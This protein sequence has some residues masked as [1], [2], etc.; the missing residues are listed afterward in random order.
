MNLEIE[1]RLSAAIGPGMSVG[2]VGVGRLGGE[3][4]DYAVSRG[5]KVLLC[6]PPRNFDEA[7]EL[8]GSFFGLWGNGMGGCEITHDG[9][10]TFVPLSSLAACDV[11][12]VQVPL[13]TDGQYPTKSFISKKIV[14]ILKPTATILNFSSTEVF[15]AAEHAIAPME[16]IAHFYPE[17]TPFRRML[18]KHSTQVRDKA[19]AIIELSPLKAQMDLRL[20]AN[21][22]MLH[23]IGIGRCDAPPILCT[24]TEPYIA[25]GV[26]GA[27]MLRGLAE[28]SAMEPYARICERHTG[29]GLT[30][31]EI[32]Q[33]KLPLPAQD[34]LPETLEEK[35]I[36]LADKFFSKS[37]DM[38]EKPLAKIRK[39]MARFGQPALDRFDEMCRLFGIHII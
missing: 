17:D 19:L 13:T 25:H 21:G 5:A 36:C 1:A 20:V 34:F 3:I 10:E 32:Q 14:A 2:I 8:S 33:E 12:T 6:D 11:I 38:Q 4:R 27:K 39:G 15:E 9:M 29:S 37:G 31:V 7:D 30:A 24:G 28:G 23:D 22:A 18:I 35:L 16:I 26:I